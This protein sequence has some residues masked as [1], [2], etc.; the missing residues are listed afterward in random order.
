VLENIQDAPDKA[1]RIFERLVEMF[2]E[3]NINPSPLNYYVW[4][5]YIKGDIPKFRQEM[6][7]I[8]NDPFGYTDRVGRRLYDE[9]LKEDDSAATEF[10]RAFRRLIDV[11]V[12][13]MNAWTDK[14]E[15]H[16]KELD[17]CTSELSNPD[18]DA[19]KVKDITDTVLSAA[20]T[21][22]ESSAAFQKEMIES[23]EEVKMLRQKLIEARSE[24]MQDELTEIGNR[25]MFNNSITELMFNYQSK[26]GKLCLILTDIDHFKKFNDNYGHLVGDSILRYFANIMKKLTGNDETVCRYGGEEFAILLAECS[27][28]KAA[29]KA[30]EIRIALENTHLKRKD[31]NKP[32]STVTASFGVA[33]FNGSESS[34]EFI[35]RADKA[36]YK[37]KDS[38]RNRVVMETELTEENS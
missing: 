12:K 9:F 7:T 20:N 10:D 21:M 36:L 6:D 17:R 3:Q 13:K 31:E 19:Q 32:I 14:L 38:G 34:E 18:I 2:E 27:I 4:Y 11:M 22:K 8:L 37:A 24:A 30:D 25:K 15:S 26:P 5:Q 29:K 33:V 1:K 23:S 16:T 28:E 35:A